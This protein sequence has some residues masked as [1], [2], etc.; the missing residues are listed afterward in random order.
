MANIIIIN[1]SSNSYDNK[2]NNNNV[3]AGSI[4]QLFALQFE[5]EAAFLSLFAAYHVLTRPNKPP[6]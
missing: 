1:S 4:Q 6:I 3:V 5:T 2:N